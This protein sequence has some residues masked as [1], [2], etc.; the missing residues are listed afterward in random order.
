MTAAAYADKKRARER[1]KAYYLYRQAIPRPADQRERRAIL[2]PAI[3]CMA[4]LMPLG[5]DQQPGHHRTVGSR[6]INPVVSL[7]GF[8][9]SIDPPPF[10][11][12]GGD[13]PGPWGQSCIKPTGTHAKGCSWIE[14]DRERER[15]REK[16]QRYLH[17]QRPQKKARKSPLFALNNKAPIFYRG[18]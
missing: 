6:L 7:T 18:K 14:K 9:E 4:N 3:T 5:I 2:L 15:T 13:T 17:L 11:I 16:E 8:L 10:A 12:W 1:P